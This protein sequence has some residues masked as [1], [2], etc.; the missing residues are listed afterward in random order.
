[1]AVEAALRP[2]CRRP[3]PRRSLVGDRRASPAANLK[4]ANAPNGSGE[5]VRKWWIGR[6]EWSVG[7]HDVFGSARAR[8]AP[9]RP[10][11]TWRQFLAQRDTG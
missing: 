8:L 7:R 11:L 5:R 6:K 10:P 4:E 1:M 2:R 3:M 9:S